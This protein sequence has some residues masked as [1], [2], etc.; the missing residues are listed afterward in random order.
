MI[1]YEELRKA[2]LHAINKYYYDNQ[3]KESNFQIIALHVYDLIQI[4][5]DSMLVENKNGQMRFRPIPRGILL[6]PW[7]WPQ[8]IRMAIR[9]IRV[10][11]NIIRVFV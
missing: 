11:I 6:M 1:S 4:I 3:Q 10:V 5:Q 8:I 2:E 9:L 7:K